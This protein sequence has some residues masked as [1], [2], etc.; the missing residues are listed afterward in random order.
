MKTFT[1]ALIWYKYRC[2]YWRSLTDS[3]VSCKQRRMSN[4][5]PRL[6]SDILDLVH[7]AICKITFLTIWL[8]HWRLQQLANKILFISCQT[9]TLAVTIKSKSKYQNWNQNKNTQSIQFCFSYICMKMDSSV[10]SRTIYLYF[11]FMLPETVSIHL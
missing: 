2:Q 3:T 10:C 5:S 8:C 4:V 7:G 1:C 11:I 6:S 9:I